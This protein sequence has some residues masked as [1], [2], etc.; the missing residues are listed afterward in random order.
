MN[1]PCP[2]CIQSRGA[3]MPMDPVPGAVVAVPHPNPHLAQQGQKVQAR[4]LMCSQCSFMP[5][6]QNGQPAYWISSKL[7]KYQCEACGHLG[8]RK[9]FLGASGDEAPTQVPNS[10]VDANGF[11]H[12][13]NIQSLP[14]L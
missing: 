5:K 3:F 12:G 2:R 11:A 9:E 8:E 14:A 13:I 6:D 4:Q 1:P 10:Y 7:H